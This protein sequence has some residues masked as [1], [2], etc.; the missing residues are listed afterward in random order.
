MTREDLILLTAD[1]V[2]SDSNLTAFYLE[3]YRE[4]YG[5]TPSC[6]GCSLKTDFSNLVNF[7]KNNPNFEPKL[8]KNTNKMSTFKLKKTQSKIFAYVDSKTKKT[9]RLYDTNFTEDFVIGFL[10]NGTDEEIKERKAMFLTLPKLEEVKEVEV[11]VVK[12]KKNRKK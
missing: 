2:R 10:T 9:H 11:E 3:T 5:F 7:L 12:E 8:I 4:V 1:Q 6:G